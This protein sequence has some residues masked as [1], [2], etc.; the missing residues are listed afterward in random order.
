VLVHPGSGIRTP[1]DLR[2]RKAGTTTPGGLGDYLY[3]KTFEVAGRQEGE[4]EIVYTGSFARCRRRS[5]PGRWT[6]C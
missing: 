4:V 6:R 5:R 3:R 1:A 2:G